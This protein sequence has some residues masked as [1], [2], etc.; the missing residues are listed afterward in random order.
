[1]PLTTDDVPDPTK[2]TTPDPEPVKATPPKVEPAKAESPKPPKKP[3]LDDAALSSDPLVQKLMWDRGVRLGSN[4]DRGV[5][6]IDDELRK[7]GFDL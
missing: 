3:G 2:K 7:L 4:D 5:A 6:L 1:M